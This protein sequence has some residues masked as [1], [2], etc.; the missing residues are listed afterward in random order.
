MNIVK[1][2]FLAIIVIF[3][4]NFFDNSDEEFDGAIMLPLDTKVLAF[5]D[6]I[7][8]GYNVE[9][10]KNYPSQLA[11]LLQVD[12]IN[13]GINGETTSEGLRRLPGLLEK[14]KPQ[15]LIICHGGNDIIRHKS[16][17]KVKENI[18]KMIE[19]ARKKN[20]H[21]V[22]VGVPKMEVLSKST[23]QLYFD[24]AN[25]LNV[26]LEDSALETILNDEYLKIDEIHP[27]GRGYKILA[28][29]LANL[30]TTTYLP[31]ETF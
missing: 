5:G 21:V 28:N 22:L 2:L 30:I 1:L 25:E 20:I 15:I 16:L 23:A 7:T 9:T 3:A 11:E 13:A 14:Y 18:K 10:K 31:S 29:S 4:F 26:P 17:K 27:N 8:Y 24:I 12:V 19:L 6:S